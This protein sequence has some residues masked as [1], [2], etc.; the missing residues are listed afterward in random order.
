MKYI[1]YLSILLASLFLLSNCGDSFSTVVDV[2][3]P[4]FVPKMTISSFINDQDS[5]INFYVGRNRDILV[6]G[7]FEEYDLD[8]AS[9]TVEKLSSSE[10][11][12]GIPEDPFSIRGFTYNYFLEVPDQ[13]FSGGESYTFEISHPDYDV[14][15]TTLQFPEAKDNLTNIV[16]NQNDGVDVE[17]DDNSSVRFDIVDDP[18]TED[19]YEIELFSEGGNGNFGSFWI[20]TTDPSGIKGFPNDNLLFS[21]QSF[22]GETK[23]I[24]VKFDRWNYDPVVDPPLKLIWK[25]LTKD[26]YEYSLSGRRYN[27]TDGTPFLSPVQLHSNVN[28]ALGNISMKTGVVYTIE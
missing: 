21:D 15:T 13:F 1:F 28:G 19:Y 20:E 8:S 9:I 26:A 5:V 6:E 24:K 22:N 16:Y 17:G 10:I 12:S 27:D 11:I 23:S 18:A 14:S 2:E 25:T 4:E 7:E 3:P